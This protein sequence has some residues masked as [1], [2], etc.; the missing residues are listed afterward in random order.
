MIFSAGHQEKSTGTPIG[1][2][3]RLPEG[4]EEGDELAAEP[5]GLGVEEREQNWVGKC[6]WVGSALVRECAS[7]RKRIR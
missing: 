5:G 3:S 4:G 1:K 7:V 2:P 6:A